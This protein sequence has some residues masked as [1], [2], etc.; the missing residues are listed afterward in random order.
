MFRDKKGQQQ[1]LSIRISEGVRDFLDRARKQFSDARGETMSI[2]D[3]AKSLL[4]S[5]IENQMDDRLETTS[6]LAQPTETLLM[7]RRKWENNLELTRAE[8]T[9]LAQ[10]VQSGCEEL[11]SDPELPSRESFAQ[12]LEAF[13]AIRSLRRHAAPEMDDY[14][15]GNLS[16][17]ADKGGGTSRGGSV[18][19]P[20]MIPVVIRRM[21]QD[22]RESSASER[23]SFVG[24]NLYVALRDERLKGVESLHRTL[25]PFLPRLYQVA[26]RG[27]WLVQ[28][29][30]IRKQRKPWETLDFIPDDVPN[31]TVGN[32]LLSSVV[33]QDGELHMMLNLKS[34]RI[35]YSLGPYP[36]IRELQ[37]M[38]ERMAP[39]KT[40]NGRYFFGH[41]GELVP[42][43][44]QTDAATS[45]FYFREHA[46]GVLVEFS[47]AEWGELKNLLEQTM[48]L[49]Q[50]KSTLKELS[51][52]YGEF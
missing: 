28:Y 12:I 24:R 4:E 47:T 39:G 8:W 18:R 1:T 9:V 50:L 3:V 38:V 36:Q 51:L 37:A 40:W 26:A 41:T 25:A 32:L 7:I 14:Y 19:E 49:P 17:W 20:D 16:G 15:L 42:P 34:H 44:R 48:K 11:S 43:H 21:V 30:P 52:Q 45:T 29:Q 23:P 31:V 35:A 10:Y 33:S 13:L 46:K 6:L 2:S 22:L 5:A 27:H